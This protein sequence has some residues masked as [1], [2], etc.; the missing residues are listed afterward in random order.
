M[1]PRLSGCRDRSRVMVLTQL[2]CVISG[3]YIRTL[4]NKEEFKYYRE[5]KIR[6]LLHTLKLSRIYSL[7]TWVLPHSLSSM[8]CSHRC[9]ALT[10]NMATASF[11]VEEYPVY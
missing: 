4:N 6:S 1:E 11:D 9:R 3:K 7:G 5:L 8:L 10:L 2:F